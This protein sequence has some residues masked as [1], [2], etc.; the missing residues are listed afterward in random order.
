[1]EKHRILKEGYSK[2]GKETHRYTPLKMGT[3]KDGIAKK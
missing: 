3:G 1:M 2:K